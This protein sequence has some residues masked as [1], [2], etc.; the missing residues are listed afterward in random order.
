[1]KGLHTEDNANGIVWFDTQKLEGQP[2]NLMLVCGCRYGREDLDVLGLTFQRDLLVFTRQ[3]CPESESSN[4]RVTVQKSRRYWPRRRTKC[5]KPKSGDE[6]REVRK[7]TVQ[8]ELNFTEHLLPHSEE[9]RTDN[10][11]LS[12]TQKRLLT[13]LGTANARPFRIHLPPFAPS[14]VTI[15]PNEG[16]AEKLCG[17]TY[18]LCTYIGKRLNDTSLI[19][20]VSMV[21]RKFTLGPPVSLRPTQPCC[22][23]SSK[24]PFSECSGAVTMTLT[25]DKP[26]FYHD[27]KMN[28]KITI[29]NRS[30]FA[31]RKIQVSVFQVTELHMVTKGCY[32]SLVDRV[33]SRD[34]LPVRPGECGWQHTYILKPWFE[35]H[36][37]RR[38]L[39]LEGMLKHEQ[40]I[41]ASS[42]VFKLPTTDCAYYRSMLSI[43][44]DVVRCDQNKMAKEL[45]G[46]IVS[47][48]VQGRCWIGM[49][50]LDV[51]IPFFL[52]R[53]S[54]EPSNAKPTV[55]LQTPEIPNSEESVKLFNPTAI[56][57][58]PIDADSDF[59]D[60]GEVQYDN[61]KT[62]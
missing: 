27:E 32:R 41:L 2:V 12:Y 53:P 3:I 11:P 9:I 59:E 46:I 61:A 50:R 37:K 58:T 48:L 57:H 54:A 16:E 10:F 36:M 31:V 33:S 25:L 1:M 18:E 30:R 29:D 28:V 44:G 20:S 55:P 34:Q 52:T 51:Q 4:Q 21:I 40:A 47:Y 13:R 7:E 35:S 6:P 39:A 23:S 42:T 26:L 22:E 14:S 62:I 8:S 17:V 45:Q 43:F 5:A 24:T 56:V 49:S 38:G 19:S 60:P 15:Q